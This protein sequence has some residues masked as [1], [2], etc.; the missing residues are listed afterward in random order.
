HIVIHTLSLHDA[1]PIYRELSRFEN[2]QLTGRF[3]IDLGEDRELLAVVNLTDQPVSDDPGGL[4]AEV[5]AENPRAAWPTHVSFRAGEA[6]DRKSTRLNS[7]H[8]KIS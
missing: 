5:A 1:L 8:V 6:L 7:S 4:T 2:R 3:N